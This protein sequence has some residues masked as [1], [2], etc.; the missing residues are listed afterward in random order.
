[1]KKSNKK[2][3]L[4]S[5]TIKTNQ[6]KSNQHKYVSPEDFCTFLQLF[7]FTKLCKI[8]RYLKP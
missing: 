6:I 4:P 7:Y 5:E 8:I 2:K 3:G 1:M